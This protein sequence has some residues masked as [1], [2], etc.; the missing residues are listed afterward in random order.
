MSLSR[1]LSIVVLR[2]PLC[3]GDWRWF[4]ML[5]TKQSCRTPELVGLLSQIVAICAPRRSIGPAIFSMACFLV[6]FFSMSLRCEFHVRRLSHSTSKY[7]GVLF[8]SSSLSFHLTA[9]GRVNFLYDIDFLIPVIRSSSD[10]VK[11]LLHHLAY[12]SQ[13]IC[14]TAGSEVVDMKGSANMLGY[15]LS[16]VINEERALGK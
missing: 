10:I 14:S 6:D 5:W 8:C 11:R 12:S 2:S 15:F 4:V 13:V 9:S 1:Q 7:V 3:S 16:N